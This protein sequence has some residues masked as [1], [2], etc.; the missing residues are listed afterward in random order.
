MG[1]FRNFKKLSN[2]PA[3]QCTG[4][5]RRAIVIG[6]DCAAAIKRAKCAVLAQIRLS[7]KIYDGRLQVAGIVGPVAIDFHGISREFPIICSSPSADGIVSLAQA[8]I[9][10]NVG[11]DCRLSRWRI[12]LVYFPGTLERARYF[13]SEVHIHQG[14][15]AF[16]M[17]VEEDIMPVGSQTRMRS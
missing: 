13:D 4:C 5:D 6:H 3:P 2:L 12:G 7:K 9:S 1:C 15:P 11:R 10:P 14:V 8:V 16:G 17:M